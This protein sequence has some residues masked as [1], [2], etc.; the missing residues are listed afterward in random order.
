MPTRLHTHI[1]VRVADQQ[2]AAR[3]YI[4]ALGGRWLIRPFEVSGERA[5]HLYGGPKGV[6]VLVCH[7]GFGDGAIELCEFLEPRVTA[8]PE[9]TSPG[10]PFPHCGV[11][12]DDIDATYG[13]I[14]PAGGR[15]LSDLVW[16]VSPDSGRSIFF[17]EDP[18]GNVME[19]SSSGL[20]ESVRLIHERLPHT[21]PA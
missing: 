1:G 6:R 15:L 8:R 12:V 5:E 9:R 13:R 7:I 21:V 2:R 3:F 18:D 4:D 20:D 14:E 17:C 16:S 19:I 11:A 10:G